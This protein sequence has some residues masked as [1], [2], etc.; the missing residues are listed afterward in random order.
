MQR[1]IEVPG[2][3]GLDA[4]GETPTSPPRQIGLS[5][6]VCCHNGA[7]RLPETLAHLAAQDD[8][9][10]PW[11]LIVVDN[12]SD[13]ATATVA[14]AN[15]PRGPA[16]LR[17]VSEPRLGLAYARLRGLMAAQYTLIAY[18]DD[19]NWL[20]ADWLRHAITTMEAHPEV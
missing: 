15:W 5:V 4:N 8:P 2:A 16:P 14:A 19:D 10:R 12:A 11:E 9:G 3:C 20:D 6:V 7:D 13:D 18:I 1:G 17:V